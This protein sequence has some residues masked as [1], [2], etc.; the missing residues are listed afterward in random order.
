MVK[1]LWLNREETMSLTMKG[2]LDMVV[3]KD[4]EEGGRWHLW[5]SHDRPCFFNKA[6]LS[7][8]IDVYHQHSP[9]SF[10]QHSKR[11]SNWLSTNTR[12]NLFRVGS[13]GKT[14]KEDY[15]T[16]ECEV[17]KEKPKQNRQRKPSNR[18]RKGK[19]HIK[20]TTRVA[21][22]GW[23]TESMMDTKNDKSKRPISPDRTLVVEGIFALSLSHE[24]KN[25]KIE[26]MVDEFEK[27]QANQNM[28][29]IV[30]SMVS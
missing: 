11:E 14:N 19:V 15:L 9:P 30:D 2:H 6:Q 27:S 17:R 8:S 20:S 12:L 13:D 18:E 3:C 21:N 26:S 29:C 22:I 4:L 10:G 24:E 7:S 25:E 5:K 23:I 16:T 28:L 1:G